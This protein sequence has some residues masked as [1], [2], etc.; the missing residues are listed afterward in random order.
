MAKG[1][2]RRAL[3]SNSLGGSMF[4]GWENVSNI[5]NLMVCLLLSRVIDLIGYI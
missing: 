1:E 4:L 3:D 2:G 5:N